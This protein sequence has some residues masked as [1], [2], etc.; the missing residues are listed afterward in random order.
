VN[1]RYE[2]NQ[3]QNI[4]PKANNLTPWHTYVTD[5][6]GA[7]NVDSTAKL[8]LSAECHTDLRA[9]TVSVCAAPDDVMFGL[10][11]LWHLQSDARVRPAVVADNIHP[12][13]YTLVSTW[14]RGNNGGAPHAIAHPQPCLAP[15]SMHAHKHHDT[16]VTHYHNDTWGGGR[17]ARTSHV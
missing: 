8:Q 12:V 16:C 7:G 5:P 6:A 1:R 13:L 14:W 11:K 15:C 3:V 17:P 10:L 2:Q 4:C 9:G